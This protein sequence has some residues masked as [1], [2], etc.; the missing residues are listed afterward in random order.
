MISNC[1]DSAGVR[2]VAVLHP[3]G[4][5]EVEV[6]VEGTGADARVQLSWFN[7]LRGAS[8]VQTIV[9]IPPGDGWHRIRVDITVPGMVAS[10]SAPERNWVIMSVSLPS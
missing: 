6:A 7:D 10:S 2:G 8:S 4:R 9:T 5:I 3:Q 1:T